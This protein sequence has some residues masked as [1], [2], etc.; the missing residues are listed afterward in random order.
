[1][2][3]T[4]GFGR[5]LQ[6]CIKVTS[7]S[8]WQRN[9]DGELAVDADGDLVEVSADP[10]W[11]VS[12]R[13]EYDN[14]GHTVRTYQPYFVDD[15]QYVVDSSMRASGYADTHFYDATGREIRVQTAL[16][17][18]RRQSYFPW[19]SVSEDE[20]DTLAEVTAS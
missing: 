4:D 20:N 3:Y 17:Y 13:L 1:V 18:V 2:T 6:S 12:G 11:A 16:D 8:A 14:K 15:W 9:A 5:H 19:F 10:R 7:G